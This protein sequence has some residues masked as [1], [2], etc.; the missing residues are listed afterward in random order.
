MGGNEMN[1]T[2][3]LKEVLREHGAELT[4]IGDMRGIDNCTYDKGV[5]VAV[6]FPPHVIR[7]LEEGPTKEYAH[8]YDVLNEKLDGIVLAGER[9]L[10][11]RGFDAYAQTLDRVEVSAENISP[12]PHKTVATRAGLGWIGKHCLLVTPELGSA[13]RI[14]SILTDAPLECGKAVTGS[15]CGSCSVCVDSCPAQ[16]L[17]G[18]LWK[19][20]MKREEIVDIQ[21]CYEKEI[22]V[23]YERT[24]IK[25]DLCGKCFAVCTYTQKHLNSMK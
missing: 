13:V 8:L 18:T 19:P 5:A 17:H 11:E 4:G 3:E 15:G 1:L 24:G 6:S 2:E 22:E 20:G 21:A 10:K 12:I 25:D 23:M 16:A 14:S 7:D 9:F